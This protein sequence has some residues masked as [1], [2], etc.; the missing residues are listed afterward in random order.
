MVVLE[1][2]TVP[3]RDRFIASSLAASTLQ[4]RPEGKNADNLLVIKGE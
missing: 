2:F 3:H 1:F 4:R